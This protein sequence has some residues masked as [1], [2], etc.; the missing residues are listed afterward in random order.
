VHLQI[1]Y[2]EFSDPDRKKI[3]DTFIRKLHKERKGYLRVGIEAKEYI[4]GHDVQMVKWNGRE[5]RNG[6]LLRCVTTINA[7]G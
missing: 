4:N 1:Y 6:Q 3:W 7:N 2:P 5:I